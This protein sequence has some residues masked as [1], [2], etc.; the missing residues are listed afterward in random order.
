[1]AVNKF[2]AD[3]WQA[4]SPGLAKGLNSRMTKLDRLVRGLDN[5]VN[6]NQIYGQ[7]ADSM[8]A[9]I[10]EVHFSTISALLTTLQTFHTATGVYWNGYR[11]VDTNGNFRLVN[12][13]L[14]AHVRDTGNAINHMN[15]F[16][17]HLRSVSNSV[18]H[19]IG[20]GSA[21]A[22]AIANV[23]N[24]LE[25][26]QRIARDQQSAWS[27][28]ED[29]DPG[30]NQVED[31][32]ATAKRL[33]NDIG[34]IKVGREYISGSFSQMPEFQ[35][36]SNLFE[37][38][39]DYNKKNSKIAQDAWQGMFDG[40]V[41]DVEA[42]QKRLEKENAKKELFWAIVG[43]VV[44]GA[45]IIAS[46]GTATPLVMAGLAFDGVLAGNQLI[47][48]ATKFATGKEFNPLVKG[49][50]A[51]GMDE[52][53][54]NTTVTVASFATLA[55]GGGVA[56]AKIGS[57]TVKLVKAGKLGQTLLRGV[58]QIPK[59]PVSAGKSVLAYSSKVKGATSA[60]LKTFGKTFAKEM[61][62]GKIYASFSGLGDILKTGKAVGKATVAG[63][64][65]AK[66]ILSVS[67]EF[68]EV[69]RIINRVESGDVPL[70][71]N[72]QKGNYGE[73][74]MDKYFAD[75]GYTR[76]SKD[77]V[78]SLNQTG[79][80]G[81]DGVYYKPD[82]KPPYVIG[83]AKFGKSRLGKTKDGKQMSDG[84][85]EG[86]VSG[87]DRLAE[88][89]GQGVAN[90]IRNGEYARKLVKVSDKGL[91]STKLLDASGKVVK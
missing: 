76:I 60:G 84:W 6:T 17:N 87:R 24:D 83:E 33:L 1:M 45:L 81:I 38:M 44:A 8:K 82:G 30:F 90:Q 91:I 54:A 16:E 28:Y 58:K 37:Q 64:K 75:K 2:Y 41:A 89:V 72:F 80:K 50:T 22:G 32:I 73:M 42:E 4:Q 49:L 23:R 68:D 46:A 51:M 7:G 48:S 12:E 27:S 3:S 70:S 66:F 39:G 15:G 53:L 62:N 18:S 10:S 25:A 86:V 29:C 11:Q 61:S 26:M 74:K 65:E 78:T 36:L 59:V 43:A 79:H 31:M 19:I 55:F 13:D 35:N 52:K 63:V 9:Y 85:I 5:L 69:S 71:N 67:D 57:S 40:Y 34:K 47:A 56:L 77:K 88:A 20:L 14:N 21:G